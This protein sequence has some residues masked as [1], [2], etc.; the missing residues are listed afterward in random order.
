MKLEF[1]RFGLVG[2]VNTIVDF[3]VFVLLYRLTDLDPLLCNGIAFFVAVTNS[4]LMNHHWTFRGSGST[5]SFIAYIRFVAFNAGGLLIGTL[6]ILLLGKYMP[7]EFA[8]LIAAGLTLIWN[9]TC[10]KLF[11]F[12]TEK[13]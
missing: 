9:Y 11:V 3:V 8:K 1:L 6:A 10:S 13:T 7:L 12:N 2:V 5:L 4:Y